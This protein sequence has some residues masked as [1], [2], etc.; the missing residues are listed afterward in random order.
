[1]PGLVIVEAVFEAN[2][3][4]TL[5]VWNEKLKTTH[6]IIMHPSEAHHA[7]KPSTRID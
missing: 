3:T 7:N 1:M 4:G 6:S 2:H 5:G